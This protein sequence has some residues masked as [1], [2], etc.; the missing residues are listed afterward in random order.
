MFS[1]K[2]S[3]DAHLDALAK[4]VLGHL[5]QSLDHLQTSD[6]RLYRFSDKVSMFKFDDE[7]ATLRPV[8]ETFSNDHLIFLRYRS[9]D[10]KAES[11]RRRSTSCKG[12]QCVIYCYCHQLVLMLTDVHRGKKNRSAPT[13]PTEG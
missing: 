3:S 7:S 10:S 9:E 12:A 1:V 11:F 2:T 13:A 8:G 6:M 4:E 5:K